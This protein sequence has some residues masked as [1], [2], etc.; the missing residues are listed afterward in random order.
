MKKSLLMGIALLLVLAGCSKESREELRVFNWGAYIDESVITEFENKFNVKVIY[1]TF[2]SNEIM[3][4]KLQDGSKYD[5]LIPSDYMIQRLN[6]EGRLQQL[7]YSKIPNYSNVINSLKGPHFDPENKYSVPYF[8]GNVGLLYNPEV[9]ALS[10][11]EAQGWNVLTNE[12]YQDNLFFYDSERDAFMVAL[13][14]LGYSMN[15]TEPAELE[16]AYQW[17]I[18]MKKSMKPVYVTDQVIDN[19]ESGIKDLAVMYSGDANYI[20]SV[21]EELEYFVPEQGTNFWLDAMVIPDNA[22]NVDLAH[23]W[24]NYMLDPEVSQ[25]ITEEVGYTSPIQSVIDAVTGPGGAYEGISSYVPRIDFPSDEEFIYDADL[26][27]IMSEY[28]NRVITTQ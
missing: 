17:L 19:M 20:M 3:Y 11:L 10:E 4:T 21:N 12:K 27:V 28:W 7:D 23:E 13:K 22:L 25:L 8:W 26:K 18:D 9:I 14:A 2:E 16:A 15:T 6:D 1:D 5:I 24:I